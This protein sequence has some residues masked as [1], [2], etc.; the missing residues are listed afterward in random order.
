M[1]LHRPGRHEVA[2]YRLRW[3]LA[4]E[5]A[6]ALARAAVAA[7][8]SGAGETVARIAHSNADGYG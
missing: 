4:A 5:R 2:D 3:E 7:H 1:D 6:L 8:T